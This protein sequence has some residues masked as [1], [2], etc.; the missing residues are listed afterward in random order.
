MVIICDICKN[1]VRYLCKSCFDCLCDM[2]KDIYFKS[3]G[4][5]DYDV[6]LLIFE[7]LDLFFEC[8]FLYVCKWYFKYCVS[9]G[10]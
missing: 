10:C 7:M 3:K 4:I 1:I 2:C 6:V 5:F 8:F 9:I